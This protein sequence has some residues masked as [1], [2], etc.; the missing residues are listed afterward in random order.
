MLG[1]NDWISNLEELKKLEK[2]K[3]DEK[4]LQEFL[5]I[6]QIKKNQLAEYIKIHEGIEIDPYSIYD[7]Q[8]KRI[9]EYKRQLLNAFHILDLYYRLKENPNLDM[10]NRTFIL[11]GKAAP[12][13]DRAKGIIKYINEI[14][15]LIN[16]DKEIDGKIKVVFVTNYGV[17]YGESYLLQLIFQNKFL[18]QVKKLQVLV[19]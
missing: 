17:S 19:I 18:Q 8:I 6:K 11:G 2:Y 12:G 4:V 10:V 15:E 9:H 1:S 3:D 14:K 7:I 16:N 5:K 13:Y